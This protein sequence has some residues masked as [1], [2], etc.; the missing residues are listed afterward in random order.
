MTI[1]ALPGI[2]YTAVQQYTKKGTAF[3]HLKYPRWRGPS[4]ASLSETVSSS[5]WYT[6]H[7]EHVCHLPKEK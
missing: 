7:Q 6:W 4:S 3:M 2:R 1:L 5:L